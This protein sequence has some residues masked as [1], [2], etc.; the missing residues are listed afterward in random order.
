MSASD[1]LLW[2]AIKELVPEDVSV[3]YLMDEELDRGLLRPHGCEED[4]NEEADTGDSRSGSLIPAGSS[5]SGYMK[6]CS[7]WNIYARDS[8][9]TGQLRPGDESRHPVH[10]H[11]DGVILT[12]KAVDTYVESYL[13]RIHILHPI[14]DPKTLRNMMIAFEPRNSRHCGAE[15]RISPSVGAGSKRKWEAG[16]FPSPMAEKPPMHTTRRHD[17][18]HG[19]RNTAPDERCL[20][21]AIASLVLALGEICAYGK[22]LPKSPR[23]LVV[24]TST[25]HSQQYPD[26]GSPAPSSDLTSAWR[27]HIPVAGDLYDKN[28]DVV[29]GLA[30]FAKAARILGVAPNGDFLPYVQANLLAGLYMG[31]L[32]RVAH[33]YWYISNACRACLIL[34]SSSAYTSGTMPPGRRNLVNFTYWSCL[35][36]ESDIRAEIDLPSSGILD[37]E[38]RMLQEIP[39]ALTLE[40][41]RSVGVSTRDPQKFLRHYCNQIQL[42]RTLNDAIYEI[43]DARSGS[44]QPTRLIETITEN[45]ESWRGLLEDWDWSDDD[46][47]ST[48][49]NHARLRGK[50]YGAKYII[51]RPALHHALSA[52]RPVMP[53][54]GPFD[55]FLDIRSDT[56]TPAMLLRGYPAMLQHATSERQL[57]AQTFERLEDWMSTACDN[58]VK[59]AIKSTT[60]F[61][62]VPGRLV[63]T[64]ILG[65]AHA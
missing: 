39:S 50:Y 27:R 25:S 37:E 48:D 64:N 1:L 7:I 26:Y 31:Q 34:I 10:D 62:K 42:R 63:V 61:D 43:Y 36:L 24:G 14:L 46:H 52:A 23:W 16:G 20:S 2:P 19:A 17:S 8:R 13:N 28:T 45:L 33:S 59:A 38:A 21:A 56:I 29:P 9:V 54:S 58:C 18:L 4:E 40:D 55:S 5:L 15:S 41:P 44:G 51:N 47:Q 22:P 60:S 3:T 49:I 32:A 6:Q 35:Q 11:L 53:T 57:P 12:E 30:R 65:T